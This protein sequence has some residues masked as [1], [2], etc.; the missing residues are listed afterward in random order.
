MA[1]DLIDSMRKK[2]TLNA[3]LSPDAPSASSA[4][5]SQITVAIGDTLGQTSEYYQDVHDLK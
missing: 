3:T 5:E 1:D 4:I 2:E